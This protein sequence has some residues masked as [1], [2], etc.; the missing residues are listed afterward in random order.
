[1]T[2]VYVY[3]E[4]SLATDIE[5][6]LR[7]YCDGDYRRYASGSQYKYKTW[8]ADIQEFKKMNSKLEAIGA[9]ASIDRVIEFEV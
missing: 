6:I 1:M 8:V 7:T 2:M 9:W 4:T 3:G 5:T